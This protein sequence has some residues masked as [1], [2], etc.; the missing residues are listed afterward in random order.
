MQ[1]A[2]ELASGIRAAGETSYPNPP[3]GLMGFST[4]TGTVLDRGLFTWGA[5]RRQN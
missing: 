2:S 4:I 1:I 5:M 3:R